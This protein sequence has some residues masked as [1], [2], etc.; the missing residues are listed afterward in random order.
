MYKNFPCIFF[1]I[2]ILKI[3]VIRIASVPSSKRSHDGFGER[4]R[5]KASPFF[6]S[7]DFSEKLDKLMWTHDPAALEVW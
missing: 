3:G 1:M 7:Y 2:N 5:D 6:F 4:E